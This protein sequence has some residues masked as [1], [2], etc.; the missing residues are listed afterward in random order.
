MGA[1]NHLAHFILEVVNTLPLTGVRINERGTGDTQ[2]PPRMLLAV[3]VYCYATGV[4]S[5]RQIEQA[6]Y[7]DVA[8]HFLSADTH[9]DHDTLWTFRRG[10]RPLL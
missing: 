2:Y 9:P 6:A 5:L 7:T 3:L 4:F 10:N 1:R 8:V